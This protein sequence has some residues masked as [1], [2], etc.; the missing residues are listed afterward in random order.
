MQGHLGE[1]RRG[2]TSRLFVLVLFAT[3]IPI[4]AASAAPKACND[5]LDNDG[6]SLIDYPADPGCASRGDNDESNQPP[7]PTGCVGVNVPAG[8]NLGTTFASYG[9]GTTYCLA[10]GTYTVVDTTDF[11]GVRM[12]S[13]DVVWGAGKGLTII[14]A[15]TEVHVVGTVNG[16]FV[17]Y[18]FRDLS[19]GN[20]GQAIPLGSNC[21]G[22]CGT[23]FTSGSPTLLN[24]RCFNNGMNCVG[25]GAGDAVL[26]NV[27][28]DGNGYQPVELNQSASCVKLNHGDLTVRN[29]NIYDN[30]GVGLW[31]DYC[32]D[33][34]W[35]IENNQIVRN[36][37]DGVMWEVSGFFVAG[38]NAIVRNNTIQDNG[39]K[40]WELDLGGHGG[41]V[42]NDGVNLDVYGNTYGGNKFWTASQGDI[43]CR[44]MTAYDGTRQ[45]GDLYNVNF[46]DNTMN[47][48]IVGACTLAGVTCSNNG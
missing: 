26:D 38:D 6:D 45:P 17:P 5:G 4:H 10:A 2:W 12:D 47:G 30:V 11:N 28:C 29:S 25:F 13:G 35:L 39:W 16:A 7:P 27:E 43:C 48:D 9:A 32:D 46:H 8:A 14:D 15:G 36:G 21:L 22:N 24:A 19:I 1:R 33:C 44:G 34:K 3:L 40:T 37:T 20:S 42:A 23:A 41:V 18:T 31:A